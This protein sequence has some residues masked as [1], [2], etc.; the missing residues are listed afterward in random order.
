LSVLRVLTRQ[1][2]EISTEVKDPSFPGP[3]LAKVVKDS[4]LT[5]LFRSDHSQLLF[6]KQGAL[7]KGFLQR[8][9]LSNRRKF[10]L[11]SGGGILRRSRVGSI[12]HPWSDLS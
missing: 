4:T 12:G 8:G 3:S 7:L 1:T 5:I 10:D 6:V 2:L 9:A 11:A